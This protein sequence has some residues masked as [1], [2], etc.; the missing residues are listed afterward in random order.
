MSMSLSKLRVVENPE[1]CVLYINFGV[2]EIQDIEEILAFEEVKPYVTDIFRMPEEEDKTIMG[3]M[4]TFSDSFGI[5]LFGYWVSFHDSERLD[6]EEEEE[7]EEDEPEE[8]PEEE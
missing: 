4:I 2:D 8:D 5:Y 6:K 7:D 1:E 3:Y